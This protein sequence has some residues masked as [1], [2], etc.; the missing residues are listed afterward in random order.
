MVLKVFVPIFLLGS[1]ALGC[2]GGASTGSGG[3]TGGGAPPPTLQLV[4]HSV[5]P[6]LTDPGIHSVYA[7]QDEDHQAFLATSGVTL[8]NQ[9]FV[10]LPGS[11]AVP[12]AYLDIVKEAASQG[13]HAL[14]LTYENASLVATL[15]QP[16][17]DPKQPVFDPDCAAKIH[18]AVLFGTGPENTTPALTV[19]G[20]DALVNRLAKALQYLDAQYPQEG[21]GQYVSGGTLQWA[22]IRVAGHSQGGSEAAYLASKI[23]LPRVIAFDSPSDAQTWVSATT[24]AL[25]VTAGVGA[26]PSTGYYGFTHAQDPLVP[27]Q[28]AENDWDSLALPGSPT[29]VDGTTTYGGSHRLYSNLTVTSTDPLFL[30]HDCTVVDAQTPVDAAGQPVYLPVWDFLCFQ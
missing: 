28:L 17:S 2:G 21:W 9:L 30:Y 29:L 6:T 10:F 24:P 22:S 15:I 19:A 23:T 8:R 26:T 3:A 7:L 5:A 1:L 12:G 25:W 13:F 18:D 16:Y 20:P 4:Q 14:G 11:T 27:L